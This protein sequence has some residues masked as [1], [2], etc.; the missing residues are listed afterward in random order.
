M[1]KTGGDQAAAPADDPAA[2]FAEAQ[3]LYLQIPHGDHAARILELSA[4][5]CHADLRDA[6]V[7]QA[8]LLRNGIGAAQDLD[9]AVAILTAGCDAGHA[10]S[11]TELGL[12]HDLPWGLPWD[13][14]EA[15][16][17]YT[18][19]AEGGDTEAFVLLAALER[20]AGREDEGI[21]WA[22]RACAEGN[23]RGCMFAFRYEF[24]SRAKEVGAT[25]VLVA[26]PGL[27]DDCHHGSIR[28][29]ARSCRAVADNVTALYCDETDGWCAPL[30]PWLAEQ[31]A[32]GR[33]AR[34]QAWAQAACDLGSVHG[35]G[36]LGLLT[37]ETPEGLAYLHDACDKDDHDACGWLAYVNFH[38]GVGVQFDRAKSIGLYARVCT[39]GAQEEACRMWAKYCGEDTVP[40]PPAEGADL[41]DLP[42]SD[43]CGT[44]TECMSAAADV[45]FGDDRDPVAAAARYEAACG[46][47]HADGCYRVGDMLTTG[48]LG[49]RDLAAAIVQ[50]GRACDLDHAMGCMMAAGY[51]LD[52]HKDDPAVAC[53]RLQR[54]CELGETDACDLRRDRCAD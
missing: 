3:R 37:D 44:A 15:K 40:C 49:R 13:L 54:A 23:P 18:R 43:L 20:D 48:E 29:A 34:E 32:L 53:G 19:G 30:G 6:C 39:R 21:A 45:R 26:A 46:L 16:R 12:H 28:T 24:L 27:D 22:D 36:Q 52:V 50:Y 17:L 41:P 9:G 47:G 2:M 5:A 35:C 14:D 8:V 33:D 25:R 4:A 7:A 11:C 1:K 38:D 51:A 42:R 10:A 31:P